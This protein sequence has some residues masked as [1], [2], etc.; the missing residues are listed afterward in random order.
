MPNVLR[1]E[2]L[3]ACLTHPHATIATTAGTVEFAD[4]GDGE[5]LLAVHG[6]LGGWDQGL[7]AAEFFRANGFRI[8]APSRPGYLGTPLTTGRTPG[9][10]ADALAALLDALGLSRVAVFAGSGGGPAAYALAA[11]HPDKVARLLQVD[12]VCVPSPIPP[13]A[14][15]AAR[16]PS[17][18]LQLW[19]LHH[20][21]ELMLKMLFKRFSQAAPEEAATR[22]AAVA[23][24]PV[25]L[26]Q[27]E[28]ILLA[29]IGWRER[30]AGVNNDFTEGTP[31]S[32]MDLRAISCPTLIMHAL[33]DT[34]VP[35]ENARHAHRQIVAS[36]LYWMKGSH[37]AFFLEEGDTAPLYALEWLRG[38]NSAGQRRTPLS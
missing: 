25:R 24:H 2:D 6:S 21:P 20:A 22:A 5:P 35:P 38:N 4:R 14:R 28:G 32:P 1:R 19:I 29:S 16:N 15:L 8:I 27:L 12:S 11:R 33:S 34:A 37:V 18:R 10:Q 30:Q 31:R 7:V 13:F 17:L 26:A 36:E 23:R 3:Q 9:A